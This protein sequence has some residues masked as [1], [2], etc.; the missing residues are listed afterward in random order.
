MIAAGAGGCKRML[1]APSD[2]RERSLELLFLESQRLFLPAFEV[3]ES[4]PEA[5]DRGRSALGHHNAER[6]ERSV[7]CECPEQGR[8]RSTASAPSFSFGPV[9]QDCSMAPL[10]RPVLSN[11]R[12]PMRA[13]GV[14]DEQVPSLRS[15][16]PAELPQ[17][18]PLLDTHAGIAA[19]GDEGD[20]DKQGPT[21][22]DEESDKEAPRW[23]WLARPAYGEVESLCA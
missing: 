13:V 6:I 12:L 9:Q 2:T 1:G 23:C 15:P 14:N 10:P 4:K 22:E 7:A 11:V 16:S 18:P 21:D 3:Q 17:R 5:N 8:L 19:C 20:A